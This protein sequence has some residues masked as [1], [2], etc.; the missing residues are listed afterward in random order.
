MP[1]ASVKEKGQKAPA[2]CGSENP[3]PAAASTEQRISPDRPYAPYAF[4]PLVLCEGAEGV[5]EDRIEKAGDSQ[6][7][8]SDTKMAY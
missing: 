3:I 8:E 7:F 6:R 2:V 4:L 5:F 1:P